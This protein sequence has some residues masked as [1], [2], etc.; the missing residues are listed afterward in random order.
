[1]RLVI[2]VALALAGVGSGSAAIAQAVEIKLQPGETLLKVEAQGEDR[3]RPDV[4]TITAGVVTAGGTAREAL[5][6]NNILSNR[7]IEA[8][9]A[10]GVQAGDMRTVGLSVRPRFNDG[11]QDRS[12]QEGRRP[13]IL[14]YTASNELELRLRDLRNAGQIVSDLFSAGANQVQGPSFSHSDPKPAQTRARNAAIANAQAEAAAYADAM[15]MRIARI[16]RVSQR[17]GFEMEDRGEIVVTGSRIVST[18][19]E[20]GEIGTRVHLWIDYALVPK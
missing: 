12:E 5:Q 13:R 10:S 3:S 15:G 14:G 4:M 8:A 18:P 20:P 7:L 11:E 19:I 6:A 1:M 9:R 2:A 17:G 16:L